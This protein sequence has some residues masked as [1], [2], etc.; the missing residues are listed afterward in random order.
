MNLDVLIGVIAGITGSIITLIGTIIINSQNKKSELQKSLQEIV[1]NQSFKEYEMSRAL[2]K[3][4]TD[5]GHDVTYYP[6]DMYLVTYSKIAKYLE[7]K[8][9]SEQE[10]KILLEE[11]NTIK[12]TYIQNSKNEN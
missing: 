3:E 5:K 4:F 1:L 2:L 9:H 11:M 12:E 6:Y 10:L 8:N 7:K